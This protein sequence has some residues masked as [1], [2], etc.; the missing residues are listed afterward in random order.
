[1]TSSLTDSPADLLV[2]LVLAW[3]QLGLQLPERDD[4]AVRR[5]ASRA[6]HTRGRLVGKWL[7]GVVQ[8]DDHAGTLRRVYGLVLG[9]DDAF[10]FVGDR[11]LNERKAGALLECLSTW[12]SHGRLSLADPEGS[13]ALLARV[14]PAPEAPEGAIELTSV[15]VVSPDSW[16]KVK[17]EPMMNV[18]SGPGLASHASGREPLTLA[19]AP[20]IGAPGELEWDTDDPARCRVRPKNTKALRARIADALRELDYSGAHIGLVPELTLTPEL[21]GVWQEALRDGRGRE[22]SLHW[23]I[24]GTGAVGDDSGGYCNRAALL[25]RQNDRDVIYPEKVGRFQLGADA[26][27]GHSLG[28]TLKCGLV[29]ELNECPD[30]QITVL[31]SRLGRIAVVVSDDLFVFSDL[32]AALGVSVVVSP[33][34]LRAQI[35]SPTRAVSQEWA[36]RSGAQA[37]IALSAIPHADEPGPELLS[38]IACTPGLTRKCVRKLDRV[39]RLE[40]SGPEV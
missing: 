14:N 38:A 30:G 12:I 29:Q 3:Q 5:Q 16:R 27:E 2:A 33:A 32:V 15:V 36:E 22:T 28:R 11:P 19:G 1:L 8:A 7:Q 25:F 10:A 21:L 37:V 39:W 23:I 20:L 4:K 18:A 40:L 34:L 6:A 17:F 26:I 35:M 9:L 13:G 31:E 24:V